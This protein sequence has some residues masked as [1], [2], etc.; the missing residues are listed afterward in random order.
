MFFEVFGGLGMFLFGMRVMSD[1]LQK[2]AGSRMRHILE[3]V[4]S[5]RVVAVLVGG[6]ITAII[7]SS[8]ATT[9]MTVGLVNAGLLSFFQSLGIVL[10]AN[11]GTT[12]TAQII[13]FKLTKIALPAI[14]VGVFMRLL[15]KREQTKFWGDFLVGFGL[16]FYGMLVMK[17]GVGPMKEAV[18]ISDLFVKFAAQ[19]ILGVAAGALITMMLQSSSAT[20]ALTIALASSG[21]IDFLG[22]AALVLGENIGTTIT[23]QLAA[24]GTNVSAKRVAVSHLIFNVFGVGIILLIFPWYVDFVQYVTARFVSGEVSV[25]RLI[26]NFHTLFNV[27]NCLLFLPLLKLLDKAATFL[28][29]G[30]AQPRKFRLESLDDSIFKSIPVALDEGRQEFM[31]MAEEVLKM[32]EKAKLTI[33][34]A[35]GRDFARALDEVKEKEV[36]VDD[37][38][39]EINF[40]LTELSRKSITEKQSK[41][42]F[43]MIYMVSNLEKIGDHIEALAKLCNRRN[44]YNLEFSPE[45][46]RDLHEI[47]EHTQ[48]YLSTIIDAVRHTPSELM[49]EVRRYESSL[50]TMRWEMRKNH[51]DRLQA[52]TCNADAGLVYVDMINSFE[53]IGDHAYNMAEA[54]SGLK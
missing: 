19:P 38:Q 9:V 24:I 23:A 51:M 39:K 13:A 5:N 52:A 27:T 48:K 32:L 25:D 12:I 18:W 46:V 3:K 37:L 16:I 33:F 42:V 45:G 49:S 31:Y 20:V 35:K 17:M 41:E 36:Y 8:S 26:A 14:G 22:A 40:Y 54:L 1:G 44:D 34:Q 7:Q 29:P 6:L 15:S 21:V 28:V 50:N 10:G 47:Y 2:I 4:T 53:K 11:I 30:E 43:S